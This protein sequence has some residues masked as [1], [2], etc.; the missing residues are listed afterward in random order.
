MLIKDASVGSSM[1]YRTCRKLVAQMSHWYVKLSGKVDAW[2]SISIQHCV[3]DLVVFLGVLFIV[4]RLRSI[5]C[6][7]FTD[8]LAQLN[9]LC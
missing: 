4:S 3:E 7:K 9:L 8:L 1:L 6:K 5:S 2:F